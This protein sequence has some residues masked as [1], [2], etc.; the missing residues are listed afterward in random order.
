MKIATM[1]F[2]SI[3]TVTTEDGK[4]ITFDITSSGNPTQM[5]FVKSGSG[6]LSIDKN[7][8][9]IINDGTELFGP[10]TGNGFLELAAFDDDEN[11]EAGTIQHIDLVI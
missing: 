8:D 9:G 11:G 4:K 5:S 3:G 1:A 2:S 6:F 7:Q 10:A